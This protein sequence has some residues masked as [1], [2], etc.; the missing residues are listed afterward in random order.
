MALHPPLGSVG[1]A[2]PSQAQEG[3]GA[4]L[5]LLFE[6]CSPL[7]GQAQL[8]MPGGFRLCFEFHFL[9]RIKQFEM[10]PPIP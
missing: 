10:Q 7:A 9:N 8:P 1:L 5:P 4:G 2:A 6:I 3:D